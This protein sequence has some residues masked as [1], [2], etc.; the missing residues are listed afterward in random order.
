ML[1]FS[2][3][4]Y[5]TIVV[6]DCTVSTDVYSDVCGGATRYTTS[7]TSFQYYPLELGQPFLCDETPGTTEP[8][9]TTASES[10]PSRETTT[11]TVEFRASQTA[12]AA[13]PVTADVRQLLAFFEPPFNSGSMIAVRDAMD[14]GK[15]IISTVI[16]KTTGA[17][18]LST[19]SD[20]PVS[21]AGLYFNFI[22]VP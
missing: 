16:S 22:G 7:G 3:P 15:Y 18:C 4:R 2:A 21:E 8:F 14:A 5:N 20:Y 6:D 12:V 1:T 10:L 11:Y 19:A 17:Q 13:L 9:F